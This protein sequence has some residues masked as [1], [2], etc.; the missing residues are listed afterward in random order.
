[1]KRTLTFSTI[2]TAALLLSACGGGSGTAD[3]D[4]ST[5]AIEGK[6]VD[7]PVQG[8][9]Y[10]CGTVSSITDR[11][12][13]FACDAFPVAFYVGDVKLGEIRQLPEDGYV[14]PQDLVDVARDEYSDTVAGLALFLQSLDDDGEIEERI[15]LDS[16]RTLQ[17]RNRHL[18]IRTMTQTQIIELLD[19]IGVLAIVSQEDALDHLRS[20]LGQIITFGLPGS[21]DNSSTEE[22]TNTPEET[23]TP[24]GTD[25]AEETDT[26]TVITTPTPVT[27]PTDESQAA[28]TFKQVY[29]DL[30]NEARAE[31]RECGSYGYFPAADP[32]TWN[33]SLYQ[34]AYEH[35]R[36]MAIS[37]TFSHTG[38][39]TQSDL[40][41]EAEHPGTGSS[42]SERIEY[43]GYTN[44]HRYGE[45][46]AAGT[47]ME[48]AVQAME[49]WLSSPDHCKN[50]MKAEF[51]EL[52]MAVYYDAGSHYQH[53]WTQD[54]GTK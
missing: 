5:P 49:G 15:T 6:L 27:T 11:D 2:L 12:G 33:E 45:N 40:T 53:Y 30:V 24:E 10:R 38:S 48:E 3:T 28:D 16:T 39:G 26:P 4:S 21:D 43:N 50:I 22:E 34:A 41:A 29:L 47:S 19:E 9:A 52:G 1:M 54:F 25:T 7:A 18:D 51:K 8:A 42:V 20:H 35:S 37:N 13:A 46:I 32:L 31:G 17:L 36:D 23:D 44:W 14:T